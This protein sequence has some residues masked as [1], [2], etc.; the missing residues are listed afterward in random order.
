MIN[1]EWIGYYPNTLFS[2]SGLRDQADG[3]QWY[4]EIYD[5]SAPAATS[6]DLGSGALPSAGYAQ[7]AYFRNIARYTNNTGSAVYD[8]TG[9]GTETDATCYAA[10]AP[11]T[12]GDPTWA[13]WAFFGGPG[14]EGAGC[15]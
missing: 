8:S 9:P 5:A 11:S 1:G 13:N 4:G 6:T 10:D 12:S 7:A 15:N 3:Y 2:A 14:T